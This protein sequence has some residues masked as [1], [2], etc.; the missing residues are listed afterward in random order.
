MVGTTGYV[1]NGWTV[2]IELTSSD[3]YDDDVTSTLT[4]GGVSATF[5][6]TT[7]TEEES[8]NT[9]YEDIETNL[10]NT[11]K[12]M[13]IAIFETLRD[14]YAGDKEE[15]FFNTLMVMLE[16]KMDDF[17]EGDDEYD[18]LKYLYDLADQY[19]NAGDFGNNITTTPWIINGV[20]TAPNGKRY[21]ITYDSS[22]QRFTSTNF[23]V[24]KYFP[25]LD[26]LKY[27][28]D[29]NNPLGSQYAN[30]KPILARWK[31]ASIDGTR[32][33]SPYTAPNR[34]VFY[35]FKN[36]EGQYSSYTFT[37]ERYFDNLEA[38]KEFIYNSNR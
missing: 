32:Q 31:N 30:A 9:D 7:E 12:L 27:I 18:A 34:K 37:V 20:Y 25:T 11:E 1:Q 21:I 23:V 15:E 3:E 13:I 4:I 17:D 29:I 22:K 35:F 2:K 6:I 26:T 10:S 14:L 38:M 24:P 33:T 5:R 36:I 28:I 16:N 8:N 19:Y